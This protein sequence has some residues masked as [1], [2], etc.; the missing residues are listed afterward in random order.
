MPTDINK[1]RRVVLTCSILFLYVPLTKTVVIAVL[2]VE[3]H[4]DLSA[5]EFQ[6][7]S[8]LLSGQRH[9]GILEKV[10]GRQNVCVIYLPCVENDSIPQHAGLDV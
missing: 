1:N 2:Y 10:L 7:R 9:G 6:P 3:G 5:S 4:K 8:S